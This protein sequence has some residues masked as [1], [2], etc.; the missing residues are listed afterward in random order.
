VSDVLAQ[1]V[2]YLGAA[3]V[4]VPLAKRLGMGSVLGYLAAGMAIGPF[5]LGF[6][7][8]EGEDI[9]HF[10]EFGVVMMLFLVGLEL[11]PAKFWRLRQAILG[12]GAAQVGLTTAALAGALMLIGLSWQASL[13]V[14]S[15]L[16]MSSTAIALQSLKEKNLMGTAA[17]RHSFAALLF[18]DIAVIPIL[19]LLPLLATAPTGAAG[20]HGPGIGGLPGWMQT[21]AVL[22][23]VGAVVAAGRWAFVPLL[24]A[25]AR[26]RLRE[27]FTASALLIVVGIAL[28]M[29]TVGLSA[30]LGTFLAGVVL[31]TSE[32]KHELE[33]DLDPFKGL[34]LGLFFMGVGASIDFQLM[35]ESPGRLGLLT[36]GVMTVKVAV[37]AGI[38]RARRLS[39]DQNLIFSI[40]L[41]QV[42]EFAFV[43]L[44]FIAGLGV[45]D[46][47]WTATFM[48]VTALSMT[49]TPLLMLLNE[50]VLLPRFGTT[51]APARA[52]DTPDEHHPVILAGFSHFGSTVG[53]F[54]RANGVE[55]TI[56]DNDSDRVD[57]L[58]RMGF[59]VY[60]GDVTR[61][62]LLE[63]AGAAHAK[64]LVSAV[65]DFDTTRTLVE[66]ARKQFPNLALMVRAR[67][68]FDAYELM[69]LGVTDVYRQHLDTSVR[70]GV[71]VLRRLGHRTYSAHRAGQQF[72]RHDEA[73]LARLAP[74]RH[75]LVDYISNMRSEIAQQE[76][77]LLAD[78]DIDP[79]GSDHAWDSRELRAGFTGRGVESPPSHPS[80]TG[81]DS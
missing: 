11:E 4:C 28:L 47:A 69:D 66:T 25:V 14:G 63:A 65:E 70:L 71:D 49:A 15:A 27:L 16:A 29:Q 62:E 79:A 81:G 48:A 58:R 53:R 72:L 42:G 22:A 60:Y 39:V 33:S 76:A 30:A 68:R 67:H 56:L 41:A 80:R 20:D 3:V 24:R 10:A 59:K 32:F 78:R 77:L 61:H 17:G 73:A 21:L 75:N 44:A 31:A 54:L 37:L 5:A 45:L 8:E 46:G 51:E 74:V 1:A 35:A 57:L 40:G 50:R 26:T 52:P 43:L 38:G 36:I 18:Q 2:V 19:A 9:M 12:V 34:L 55:A 13:A 7:G 23:A 64:I 6:V